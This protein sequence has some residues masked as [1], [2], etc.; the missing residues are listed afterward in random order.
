MDSTRKQTAYDPLLPVHRINSRR[1]NQPSRRGV[2]R[3]TLPKPTRPQLLLKLSPSY[4]S[5]ISRL[6]PVTSFDAMFSHSLHVDTVWR[7]DCHSYKS[8]HGKGV[9]FFAG[10]R[11][12]QDHHRFVAQQK[13][14]AFITTSHHLGRHPFKKN[15]SVPEHTR[16]GARTTHHR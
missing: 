15:P 1:G 8:F 9:A 3:A 2:C 12:R 16:A 5:R 13:G 7:L 4:F 10:A 14:S 11:D 6:S